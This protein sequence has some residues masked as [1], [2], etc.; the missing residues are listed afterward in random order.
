MHHTVGHTVTPEANPA[1]DD[2]RLRD[3]Y[4]YILAHYF[5]FWRIFGYARMGKNHSRAI[6]PL[7]TFLE[8]IEAGKPPA[9]PE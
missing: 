9:L 5:A 7:V 4:L 2:E 8:A 1:I 3:I 6:A